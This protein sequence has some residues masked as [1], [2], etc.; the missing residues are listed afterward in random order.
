MKILII[1]TSLMAL[2]F[3]C[4]YKDKEVKPGDAR[5]RDSFSKDK[6]IPDVVP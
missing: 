4:G 6:I 5:E 1:I 2:L 3:A